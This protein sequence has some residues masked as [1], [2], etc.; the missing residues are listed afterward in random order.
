MHLASEGTYIYTDTGLV[1]DPAKTQPVQSYAVPSQTYLD[2]VLPDAAGGKT[3]FL[4]TFGQYA[5]YGA[6]TV[7]AFDQTTQTQT[8]SLSLVNGIVV[9][10]ISGTGLVRW[11]SNGFAMRIIS[12][13]GTTPSSVILFTSSIASS[14]NQNPTPTISSLSPAFAMPGGADF[15]LTVNGSGF[16]PGSTVT[17]NGTPRLT[18]VVSSSQLTATVYASD[19]AVAGTAQVAVSSPGPGGGTSQSVA[20]TIST[21]TPVVSVTPASVTFP[22]QTV[23]T[24]SV[25]QPV[26]LTNTGTGS[27]TGIAI[28]LVGANAASF[29]E[30]NSC[31]AT[32]AAGTSCTI[33]VTFS[34][35]AVGTA[36]ASLAITDNAGTQSAA[37]SGSG[38]APALP[39]ASV[40]PGSLS[41]A[42][43]EVG[44]SSAS[45][46]ATLTNSGNAALANI[47]VAISGSNATSFAQTTNCGSSLPAGNSCSITVTFTPTAAGPATA[48]LTIADNAAT[49]PQ[50][51]ALSGSSPQSPIVIS[52]QTGGSTSS[53]VTAGQQAKYALAITPVQGYSGTVSFSCNNLPAN[54]S[55]SFNPSSL[56]VANGSAANFTVTIATQSQTSAELITNSVAPVLACLVLIFPLVN[57]RTRARLS[58]IAAV[59]LLV[60]VAGICGCGG[61]SSGSG[62]KSNSGSTMVAP[63]TYTVQLT[64]SDGKY[65]ATQSITLIVQ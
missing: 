11:G 23:G 19:I 59:V 12:A 53:T 47:A 13:A 32:L 2:S 49:S 29:A 31:G 25:A 62:G 37:L 1:W 60:G 50:S 3:Y 7:L 44:T 27:L 57:R 36:S 58:A 6:T 10:N 20:F 39:V 24:T 33:N 28:A 64:A 17:W 45:Q 18:T 26:V 40:S 22:A 21:S 52:A 15:Q 56:T 38:T 9:P 16:V 14:A 8:G 5:Q 35:A 34:P 65:S 41:F 51:V 48:V 46:A 43:Q 4:N 55:C 61:G 42:S 63:G 30:S 54:A